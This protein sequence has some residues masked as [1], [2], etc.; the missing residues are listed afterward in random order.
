[1]PITP[2][3]GKGRDAWPQFL[4]DGQRFIYMKADHAAAGVYLG[5]LD[6]ADPHVP[7][8]GFASGTPPTKAILAD[9]V[10]FF[11]D[12]TTLM[13]QRVQATRMTLSG[14]PVRVAENIR[15]GPPGLAAF[16]AAPGGVV[17]Y[18]PPALGRLAQ[19]TWVDRNGRTI[20]RLGDPGRHVAVSL[21]PD[22]TVALVNEWEEGRPSSGTVKRLD[23]DTGAATTL[24]T[25]AAAP[26]WSPDGSQ[27]VYTQFSLGR[28]APPTPTV[29]A[30]D[31]RA[32]SHTLAGFRGQAHATDWSRDGR[33][34]VGAAPHADTTWDVWIVDTKSGEPVRDFIREPFQQREARIS[35]DGRWLAYAATDARSEWNVYVRSFPDG[36]A[37]RRVSTRGG[38]S[39]RW[40]SDGR[41]L[42]YV[43][44]GGRLVHVSISAGSEFSSGAPALL[45]QHAG[46]TDA[47]DA[48]FAYDVASDGTRFLI[49]LPTADP[50]PSTPIVVMLNW[51]F[52]AAR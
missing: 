39:P 30:L 27:V 34:I 19:L 21:S 52:P 11:L 4:S 16:D 51:K 10:L 17:S 14:E 6:S 45:S 22:G 15:F 8:M 42:Y 41:A 13:A 49:G 26:I 20:S 24:F 18:R 35:P 7:I 31:G 43:E 1:V 29:A 47:S 44:P 12:D 37:L 25:N 28:G 23:I 38:R 46:L 2:T 9:D 32:A 36:G 33:F 48:G 3:E 5:R 50:V 40:Q